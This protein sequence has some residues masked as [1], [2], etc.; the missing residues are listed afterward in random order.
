MGEGE[1]GGVGGEGR[2]GEGGEGESHFYVFLCVSAFLCVFPP[3][4]P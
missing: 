2:E 1:R 4:L 3:L